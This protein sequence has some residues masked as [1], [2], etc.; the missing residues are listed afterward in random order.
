[1][2][3]D[4][5]EYALRL[6]DEASKP[7]KQ[8]EAA[9]S[10]YRSA[11]KAVEDAEKAAATASKA[12]ADAQGKSAKEI[13]A[14]EKAVEK[15]NRDLER[16]QGG[17]ESSAKKVLDARKKVAAETEKA[18]ADHRKSLE[19]V[20]EAQNKATQDLIAFGVAAAA[21]LGAFA[22]GLLIAGEKWALEAGEFQARTLAALEAIDGSKVSAK[23][24][25]DSLRG[26]ANAA[27]LPTEKVTEFY[28]EL[29]LAG[30]A[31]EEVKDI[32]AAGL[33]VS[34]VLGDQA[35]KGVI[36]AIKG[37]RE[38][39]SLTAETLGALKGAGLGDS[40]EFYQVLAGL[41][42]A[43]TFGKTK[44][45]IEALLKNNQ[46]SADVGTQAILAIVSD[47]LDKG[48]P[49]GSI[50]KEIGG[51]SISGQLAALKNQM[52]SVFAD[53]AVTGPFV[54]ALK[55]INRLLDPTTKS[56]QQIR[57]TLGRAF[58]SV[59]DALARITPEDIERL[60]SATISLVDGVLDLAAAFKNSLGKALEKI[61]APFGQL[62]DDSET[63]RVALAALGAAAEWLAGALGTV[64]GSILSG[65][66]ALP[67]KLVG[68]HQSFA[69]I[70]DKIPDSWE[71]VEEWFD[72]IDLWDVG[73]NIVDGLWEGIK[74][75]WRGL[76]ES[77]E[78][79]L[80]LLPTAAKK[81][82]GIASPSKVFAEIG[83]FVG[84]GFTVGINDNAGEAQ[85]AVED[86]VAP[87]EMP[88]VTFGGGGT[89]STVRE[90]RG[91]GVTIENLTISPI[92]DGNGDV[93]SQARAFGLEFHRTIQRL[94]AESG[95]EGK[96]A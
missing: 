67:S 95:E 38:K 23:A 5:V 9:L 18:T 68:L 74:D 51:G 32:L 15:A 34:A 3:D 37:L 70:F 11:L 57:E 22:V 4:A 53:S 45:Q 30:V 66:L 46:V 12:L 29:R 55:T 86:L 79:L 71:G 7:A 73:Q 89:S 35:G 31:A 21:T 50:A 94:N 36:E 28:K 80:D 72:S 6:A 78:G 54:E 2:S 48:G 25:L 19:R 84:E 41:Q 59:A 56:G 61:L 42:G 87:P 63:S 13:T 75:G 62:S 91:G 81:A 85:E 88:Q 16:A 82:L 17:A 52:N 77:I 8:A 58:Q 1:M 96:A 24:T 10:D 44:A 49:L 93:E 27:G 20:S 64:A 43:N 39:G 33:D 65:F 26:A 76:L 14:A 60:L 90:F 83:G 40:D 69:D 47:K 92:L